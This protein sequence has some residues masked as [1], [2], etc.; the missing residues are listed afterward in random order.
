MV[1]RQ[2]VTL[3]K[4]SFRRTLIVIVKMPV[5]KCNGKI[6]TISCAKS[7]IYSHLKKSP[8]AIT[9]GGDFYRKKTNLYDKFVEDNFHR[10]FRLL[11]ILNHG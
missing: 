9:A 3:C 2:N 7:H 5:D 8:S 1:K 10:R 4:N 6:F 11:K